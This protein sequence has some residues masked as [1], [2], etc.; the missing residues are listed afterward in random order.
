MTALKSKFSSLPL[1]IA[2]SVIALASALLSPALAQDSG[3]S[4]AVVYNR[5]LP[6][7]KQVAAYYA[8]RRGVPSSQV[9]GFDLPTSETISR[10]DYLSK[11]E[12]PFLHELT[13]KKLFTLGTNSP[14]SRLAD[15]KI[16]YAILCYGVPTK[17]LADSAL[18][19][20]GEEKLQLELRRNDASV[21]SQLACIALPPEKV[22]WTGILPNPF[23]GASNRVDLHPTNGV[24]MVTRLDGPSAAIAQALVDKAIDA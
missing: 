7:S 6:E 19:E 24:L 21:D 14:K 4:V 13:D 2:C 9:F 12:E 22:T 23:Y 8:E 5:A 18:K 10:A 15:A 17:I 20:G 11:L 16:R 3:S 1:S